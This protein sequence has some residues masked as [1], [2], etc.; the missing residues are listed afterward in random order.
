MEVRSYTYGDEE[1][2]LV[3]QVKY[4][5]IKYLYLAKE[6]G[7]KP[8]LR[9]IDANKPNL[10]APIDNDEEFEFVIKLFAEKLNKYTNQEEDNS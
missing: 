4:N 7:T 10:I 2:I 9:K 6:D 5:D 3:N 1:Y 8:H